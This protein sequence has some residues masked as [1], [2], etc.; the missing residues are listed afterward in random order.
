MKLF[1]SRFP[2]NNGLAKIVP[3]K[4]YPNEMPDH[5]F[6]FILTTGRLLEHWHT[7]SMTRKSGDLNIQEPEAT[8][9]MDL[10]I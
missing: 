7:G 2:T 3:V 9:S 1:F 6:P 4:F 10:M 8:V 5:K